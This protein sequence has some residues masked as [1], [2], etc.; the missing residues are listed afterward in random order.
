M[1]FDE[2]MDTERDAPEGYALY[3]KQK[4]RDYIKA[5]NAFIRH[6]N[7]IV[8]RGDMTDAEKIAVLRTSPGRMLR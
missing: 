7:D 4:A 3:H 6:V 2:F 8:M 5:R 1:T